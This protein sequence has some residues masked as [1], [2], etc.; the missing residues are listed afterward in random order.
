MRTLLL[1]LI[2]VASTALQA[3]EPQESEGTASERQRFS[4]PAG[5]AQR[6]DSA[7]RDAWQNPEV[8]M[9]MLGLERGNVVADLGCG[10]GYFTRRLSG[11]VG[12]EGLVYAVDIEQAMLDH[13]M[14]RDDIVFPGNVVTVL[15]APDDPK[16][17]DGKLDLIFT[18]NTW[19]HIGNRVA[20]LSRL[21]RALKPYG[22][23]AI[24]D[25]HEGELPEGP[26]PGHKVSRDAVVQELREGGWT[27]TSES[28][29][30]PYQYFLIF[31]APRRGE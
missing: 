5:L 19:H 14:Q 10:T 21:E 28:V 23:L 2:L 7:E 18:G 6:W 25:W 27:L 9:R 29:G 30:L 3:A 20:Y 1:A 16:L 31:E 11:M 15:A 17:P 22:R 13:V 12:P 26:P 24:I 4:D 8:V